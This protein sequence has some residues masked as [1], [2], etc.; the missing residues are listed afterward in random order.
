METSHTLI[1]QLHLLHQNIKYLTILLSDHTLSIRIIKVGH[2]SLS[3]KKWG[4]FRIH[5][6][7]L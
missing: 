6:Y 7:E 4:N 1:Y 5:F 3:G 2:H